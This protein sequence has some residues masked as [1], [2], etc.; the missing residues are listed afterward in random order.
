MSSHEVSSSNTKKQKCNRIIENKIHYSLVGLKQCVSLKGREE[1]ND[2]QQVMFK[3]RVVS[4]L[5]KF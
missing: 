2:L 4:L 3:E 1:H 5:E